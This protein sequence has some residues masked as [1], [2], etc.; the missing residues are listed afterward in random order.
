MGAGGTYRCNK[1]GYEFSPLIGMG[2]LYPTVCEENMKK[3]KKGKFGERLKKFME[4]HPEGKIDFKYVA[5][6][7]EDCG[8]YDCVMDLG[9][10]LPNENKKTS[11]GLWNLQNCK[12]VEDYNHSCEDCGGK[13]K[14]VKPGKMENTTSSVLNVAKNLKCKT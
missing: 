11:P 2:L 13:M 10:Y 1:C 14:T 4:E 8:Y 6:Q 12:K 7:C 3:V 5:V 9:M